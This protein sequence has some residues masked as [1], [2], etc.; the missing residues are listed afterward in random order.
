MKRK[1]PLAYL[2]GTEVVYH[3]RGKRYKGFV[4][5]IDPEIGITIKGFKNLGDDDNI[6]C[7][8]WDECHTEKDFEYQIM[9]F[10]L[11]HSAIEAG[12]LYEMDCRELFNHIYMGKM[13]YRGCDMA[14][15]AFE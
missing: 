9:G 5:D 1:N 2:K 12:H 13:D 4:A 14:E 11:V 6:C 15:C 7:I 8:N 10:H 3:L